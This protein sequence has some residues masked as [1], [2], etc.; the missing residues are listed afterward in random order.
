VHGDVVHQFLEIVG[1]GHKVTLAIHFDQHADF[2]SGVNVAGYSA[3]L[4]HAARLLSGDRDSLLAQ[5]DDRLLQIASGFGE[6]LLAIHHR[7]SGLL[8]EL[9]H[10]GSGNIHGSCAHCLDYSRCLFYFTSLAIGCWSLAKPGTTSP[11]KR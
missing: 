9:F 8:P 10:L 6:G 7:C 4:G 5:Q 2:A 3:F 11:Y 1:A